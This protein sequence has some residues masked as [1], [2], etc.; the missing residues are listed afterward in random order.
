M[1]Q[2]PV[3]E[4]QKS[5][6][7][8]P[9]EKEGKCRP[10]LQEV[11]SKLRLNESPSEK[12]GKSATGYCGG[13]FLCASM[14]VPPKR[15][16][17]FHRVRD[18]AGCKKGLNESPSEK[19]GK[20]LPPSI[21]LSY[22]RASMKVPP[23]RKGNSRNPDQAQESEKASMKVPP[24]RKGNTDQFGLNPSLKCLNESPS[25]KEGKCSKRRSIWTSTRTPQ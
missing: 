3:A 5:L 17:N 19:E 8:S 4:L 6:N 21:P 18:K 14:K 9:S 20:S 7:E 25:E 22:P 2:A 1:D 24:K 12:E 11:I 16:G 15:K 23:K 13:V 10:V